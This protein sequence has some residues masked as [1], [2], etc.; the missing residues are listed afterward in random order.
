MGGTEPTSTASVKAVDRRATPGDGAREAP[1]VFI[2]YRRQD[3]AAHAFLLH[4][5][6]TQR[7]GEDSVFLDVAALRPGLDWRKEI[8][9]RTNA[10]GVLIALIGQ[11]WLSILNES[12]QRG[13]VEAVDDVARQELESALQ[14]RGDIV[15]VPVLVDGAEMPP[16]H[17]L[18]RSLRPLADQQAEQL[19]LGTYDQDV[20]RLIARLKQI[21]SSP[22]EATVVSPPPPG[23]PPPRRG[24]HHDRMASLLGGAKHVVVVLGADVNRGCGSLPDAERLAAYLARQFDY[25][26]PSEQLRLPAVAEYVHLT[27]GSPDL[28]LSVKEQLAT[29]CDPGEVHRFLARLPRTLEDSGRP[30]RHQLILTSNYDDALER[31]FEDEREPFDLAVYTASTG[32]FMHIPWEGEPIR[33]TEPNSYYAFPI[34]DDFE[35]SRSVIVKI[36]GAV[37]GREPSYGGEDDYV[38]TED[39]YIDY[40]SGTPV[41]DIV[42]V[43]I[44]QAL[45]SSHCLFLGYDVND[46]NSRVLLKRVWNGHIRAK[47]WAVEAEAGDFEEVVWRECGVDVVDEPVDDYVRALAMSIGVER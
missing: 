27:W 26:P 8:H 1:N 22:R 23:D 20:E 15:V 32:G 14:R 7:F 12:S 30:R 4:D 10:C 45:R 24:T 33:I 40:L 19:G 46:W 6:L 9:A 37:D 11:Q 42:P 13:V 44:L 16:A 2:S 29:A 25:E 21:A 18:P 41:Q 34:G 43:Q 17:A 5:R 31:A 28:Y 36:H 47:S 35:L 38:I 39:N 3:A